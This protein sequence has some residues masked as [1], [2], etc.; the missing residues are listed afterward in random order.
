MAKAIRESNTLAE[1]LFVNELREALIQW[2]EHKGTAIVIASLW[3]AGRPLAGAGLLV[4]L[5]DGTAFRVEI[6]RVSP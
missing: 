2:A 3:Q 4:T 1:E 5:F 6:E